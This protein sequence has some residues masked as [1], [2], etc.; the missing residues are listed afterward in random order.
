MISLKKLYSKER[1]KKGVTPIMASVMLLSFAV[2]VGVV[3]M[4]MGRAEVEE[5]AVCPIEVGLLF[6]EI[7]GKSDYCYDGTHVRFTVENGVNVNVEGLII[8]IIGMEKAETIE[9]DDAKLGKA[10]SYVGK[11]PFP[12]EAG[13]IRQLKISPKVPL[14]GVVEICPDQALIVEE[15]PS[16]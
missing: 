16:C 7:S 12:A 1:N 2:A 10:G 11:I 15:V 14:K 3:V 5:E 4:S 8:N 13:Q 6:A 9:L